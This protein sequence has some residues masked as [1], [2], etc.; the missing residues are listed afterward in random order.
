MPQTFWG[1]GYKYYGKSD[2]WPDGSYIT[3]EFAVIAWIPFWPNASYRVLPKGP[4]KELNI[5]FLYHSSS[6]EFYVQEVPL[7]KK[8]VVRVLGSV[9]AVF[10][11][12]LLVGSLL[13]LLF[14][15]P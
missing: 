14:I 9:A 8:Q 4:V 12:V 13:D 6:Q 15:K 3:T 5:P 2:V 1:L 10:L 7:N 11:G